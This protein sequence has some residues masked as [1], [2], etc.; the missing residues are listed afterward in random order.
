MSSALPDL[1]PVFDARRVKAPNL[2]GIDL[3]VHSVVGWFKNKRRVLSSLK[4]QALRIEGLEKEIHEL[5]AHNF[6]EEVSVLRDVARRGRLEGPSLDR[7]MAMAREAAVRSLG[8]RPFPVQIAGALGMCRGL[9]IEMATGEGKTLTASLAASLW[10]WMG[11]PVHV[12]TVNDYLVHRDAE[13]MR[14]V[15]ELLG[16][17]V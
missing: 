3:Q 7:A 12:I 4:A 10:G 2:R 15:Y 11:R 13:E 17:K 14:P 6:H 9:V 5:S 16:L 8:L 1:W